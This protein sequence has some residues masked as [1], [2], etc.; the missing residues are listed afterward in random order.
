MMMMIYD[1]DGRDDKDD[2]G[3][4]DE[5]GDGGCGCGFAFKSL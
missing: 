1:D 5:N 3:R 2:D 4:D